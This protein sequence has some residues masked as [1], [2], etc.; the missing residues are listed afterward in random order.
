MV[1][2]PKPLDDVKVVKTEIYDVDAMM[3][4][5][6]HENI[7][8]DIKR[9]LKSYRRNRVNGNEVQVIYEYGKTLKGQGLG[10][11]YP[12]KG[13]GLQTFPSDIRSALAQKYYWDIDMVNAQPVLLVQLCEKNG[14]ACTAL[15]SYVESRAT[16]L[17]EVMFYFD[18][19]RAEAKEICLSILFGKKYNKVPDFLKDLM[20]ELER[21]ASNVSSYYP[22]VF[23]LCIKKP[24]PKASC[25]AHIVQS[26]EA[27]ILRFIDL[28]LKEKG[29]DMRVYIHDG[30]LVLRHEGETEFPPSILRDLEIEI[31]AEFKIA[32]SLSQKTMQHTFVMKNDILRI[33]FVTELE[34]Q[35]KKE[36]FEEDHFYCQD[37]ATVCWVREDGVITHTNKGDCSISFSSYNFQKVIEGKL[38]TVDFCSEWLMDPKKRIVQSLAFDPSTLE[39]RDNTFNTFT[40][41]LSSVDTVICLE[42]AAVVERF[43]LLLY[44]NAGKYEDL[45]TY[46]LKWF[47]MLIQK[48]NV[49]PGVSLILVNQDQGTGKETL[50][51]FI[52]KKVIGT[53][54]YKNIK[55]VETELFDSHST[56]LEK[57]LF[58]KLEEVNG[59]LNRKHAD[60]VKALITTTSVLVNPKGV[61]KYTIDA[62]PHIVMTTNNAVPV[63]IEPSDRRFCISYTSSDLMGQT[64]FWNETYRLF[65]LPGAGQ[66]VYQMLS[67][68]DLSGFNVRSFPKSEYHQ[69]LSASERSSEDLFMAQ[70][71]KFSD[72]RATQLHTRY[73]NYC[74]RNHIDNPK[75]IIHFTRC[76]APMIEKKI[77]SR[78]VKDGVSIYCKLIEPTS[79]PDTEL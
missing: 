19:D 30:G 2:D 21:I 75:G 60:M 37:S 66:A 9:L 77:L 67:Q 10:R 63:K 34:Y 62:Y 59:S 54:Y 18:C 76:L 40:G 4:L 70:C 56:A 53:E 31:A 51:E 35:A 42:A 39:S 3:A 45:N 8:T 72:L 16:K 27:S 43:K 20:S 17:Q 74:V 49:V 52:G 69:T 47:A 33:D 65:D 1:S 41:L 64:E 6:N 14:W 28:K 73:T 15:K 5:A 32:V 55:N 50:C 13:L 11:L 44:H 24:N 25:L 7:P 38:K 48:P 46:M 68:I 29:R 78:K 71:P 57:T 23:K 26:L 36:M 22:E 12:L 58:L 61:K 79:E